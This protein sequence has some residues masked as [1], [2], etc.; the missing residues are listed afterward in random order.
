M[1]VADNH[2]LTA[3]I[4]GLVGADQTE[5]EQADVVQL[6][7]PSISWD[8]KRRQPGW[9]QSRGLLLLHEQALRE[10]KRHVPAGKHRVGVGWGLG[11]LRKA[12]SSG[13]GLRTRC[14]DPDV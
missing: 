6:L 5:R 12:G 7:H 2:S 9:M 3:V 4:G 14:R 13:A 8:L 11:M 10:R 1:H